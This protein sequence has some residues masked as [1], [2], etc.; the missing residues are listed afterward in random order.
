MK[1]QNILIVANEKTIRK[2]FHTAIEKKGYTVFNTESAEDAVQILR[3][4]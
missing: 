2:L 4:T 1:K 3:N